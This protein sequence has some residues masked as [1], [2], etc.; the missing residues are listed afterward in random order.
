[1]SRARAT[2]ALAALL[3]AL[4]SGCGGG[5]AKK[6]G[7]TTAAAGAKPE[8]TIGTKNFPEQFVLG[9]LY[10]QSLEAKGFRVRLKS[11][12]G[13]SEI[14]DRALI[15]GS[16]DMYPEYIG[17]ALSELAGRTKR[18][19]SAGE[20]YREAKSFE[21]GRGFTLL[22]KTPF[23]DQNALAV[24]PAYAK[25]H[26]LASIADLRGV[27]GGVVIAAPPEFLTRF[28]GLVGLR[29][30]YGLTRLRVK[31]LKIGDQYAALDKHM[32]DAANVFTTD[33]QLEKGRYVLLRDPRNLFTFQNVAPVIRRDLLRKSPALRAAIDAV[34][35]KLTTKA[36]RK[37]NADVV[38]RGQ[39]PAAVAQRFLRQA[40]LMSGPG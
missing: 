12:I 27:A 9:E 20:A 18:P 4:L 21:E 34:S 28:E 36:M 3:I 11:D 30:L 23:S 38:Q 8:I 26:G 19:H 31:Q 17:V 7:A 13:S 6:A 35:S 1:M 5:A 15:A 32:A 14:V 24:L 39:Q 25:R 10:K 40:G 29:Q 33:G 16:L 2:A 37:M 22:A